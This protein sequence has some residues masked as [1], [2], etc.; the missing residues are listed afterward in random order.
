MP[1]KKREDARKYLKKYNRKR[2]QRHKSYVADWYSRNKERALLSAKKCNLKKYGLDL[3]QYNQMLSLQ[4]N[5]CLIC[6]REF[7]FGKQCGT[8]PHIDH[9]HVTKK[10]VE[11]FVEN[12]IEVLD[13]LKIAY[14]F[15][16]PLSG[17][18][19]EKSEIFSLN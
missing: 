9:N 7:S 14:F 4:N 5:L 6:F 17:I 3:A 18:L 19:Q 10:S 11:L 2:K 12:V 8:T 15:L 13:S 1:F 16:S